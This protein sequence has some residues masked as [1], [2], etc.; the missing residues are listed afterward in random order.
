MVKL[1]KCIILE[2]T[3]MKKYDKIL[4]KFNILS[5]IISTKKNKGYVAMLITKKYEINKTIRT[6]INE[7][8]S[9]KIVDQETIN[10]IVLNDSDLHRTAI[11]NI[12]LKYNSLDK[13]KNK[14]IK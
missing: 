13:I 6:S 10:K 2:L 1:Y 7:E 9:C 14:K 8:K 5:R 12:M 4:S 3:Y 11:Y